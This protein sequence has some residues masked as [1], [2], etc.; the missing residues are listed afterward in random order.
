MV[1]LRIRNIVLD[2]IYPPVCGFC[3]EINNDF[4]CNKCR[5]KLKSMKISKIDDYRNAP[6]YFDEHF[7]MFKY[8]REIRDFIIKYK[9]DEKSYMF[10]S[11]AKLLQEDE[12]FRNNFI[13]KYDYIISVPIHKKRFKQRGYNQSELIAKE[14]GKICGKP[15]CKNVLIKKKSIVAQSTLDKLERVRNIKDAFELG[16]EDLLVKGKKIAIFDDVFTTGATVNECAKVLKSVGAD[17]V[18][19]FTIAKS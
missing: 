12:C 15:Y 11:Y 6:V 4:L 17:F 7:Y 8:E 14:I 5:N 18:G 13:D 10:K 3:N 19:V 9:F 16:Q 1:F 2:L